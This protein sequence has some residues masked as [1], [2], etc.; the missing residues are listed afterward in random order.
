MKKNVNLLALIMLVMVFIYSC[1]S[2][3]E[4]IKLDCAA[5]MLSSGDSRPVKAVDA[6]N[7]KPIRVRWESD[8]P[9]IASVDRNGNVLGISQGDAKITGTVEA[10]GAIAT[11]VVSV[12]VPIQNPVLP[13]SWG[14]YIA[15]PEPKVYE[16]GIF[17]Y[18]SKDVAGGVLPSGV[19]WCSDRYHVLHSTDLKHWTDK[20]MSFHLDWVP[21]EY[22]HPEYTRLWAPD[23]LRNPA[24]GKYYLYFCFN[25]TKARDEVFMV[26]VSDHPDGPFLNPK[27]LL[28]DGKDPVAGIDPGVLTDDDGKAYITWPFK[29]GQLDPDD[30]TKVIGTSVVDVKQW[31]PEENTP[32]E[33]PSL[34][35]KGDTY[36]YIYIE[37]EGLRYRPDGT[38]VNKPTRMVYMTSDNPL[39]PYTYQG[40]ILANSDYPGVINIHGSLVE[41]KD[42][43]Y[44]FYHMPLV[45]KHLTRVMCVEPLEIGGDGKIVPTVP[46]SS[47]IRGTFRFGDHIY[48]SGAVIYP[49][50]ELNPQYISRDGG[51][52]K[53]VF[54]AVGSYL[55]YRYI[56]AGDSQNGK[57]SL[58]VNTQAEGGVFEIRLGGHEG[59]IVAQVSVP[60]T[61]GEWQLVDAQVDGFESGKHSFYI[62]LKEKP[63]T[64][65]IGLDWLKF[66][67]WINSQDRQ[68]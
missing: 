44:V 32:Y 26:A 24:N 58:H 12:D 20:G 25:H 63:E 55:G 68:S 45:D 1:Q 30:F 18:G 43:W 37:N 22:M 49:G 8:D 64:G 34:R 36:Y 2:S 62:V 4:R 59:K 61:G 21:E 39:G 46:S 29:V 65:D 3:A 13:P 11:C 33:G 41:F 28:I 40:L 16:N 52:P 23:V 38:E 54:S 27:P 48:A 56:D 7:G 17:V 57:I 6:E 9:S 66:S 51:Y 60:D 14:L 10:T 35:K 53:P 19:S 31:M 47:G 50:N 15:D 67:E 5:F 42:K